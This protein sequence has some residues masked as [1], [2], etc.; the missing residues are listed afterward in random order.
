MDRT[1]V[2]Y[3]VEISVEDGSPAPTP[4][5]IALAIYRGCDLDSLDAV[6]VALAD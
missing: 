6:Y 2:F 4:E 1:D 3:T 5:E